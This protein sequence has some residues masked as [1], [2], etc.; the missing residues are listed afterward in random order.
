[1]LH[2]PLPGSS[3]ARWRAYAQAARR[4]FTAATNGRGCPWVPCSSNGRPKVLQTCASQRRKKNEC[5]AA[6]QRARQPAAE[7]IRASSIPETPR[8]TRKLTRKH[9][10]GRSRGRIR[11]A[12]RAS[13][14]TS[15]CG[16]TARSRSRSRRLA[17]LRQRL[18]WRPRAPWRWRVFLRMTCRRCVRHSMP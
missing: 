5:P 18:A 17:A 1:M 11:S 3:S 4:V 15:G 9:F 13:H 8:R 14:F 2:E 10:R 6:R 12:P 16:R 7:S